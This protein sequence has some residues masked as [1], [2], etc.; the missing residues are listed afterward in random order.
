MTKRELNRLKKLI[1]AEFEY[2]RNVNDSGV[3]LWDE[4]DDLWDYVIREHNRSQYK[5]KLTDDES[6]DLLTFCREQF[7]QNISLTVREK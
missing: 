6:D 7:E 3:A 2:I 4:L 5:Q 1:T